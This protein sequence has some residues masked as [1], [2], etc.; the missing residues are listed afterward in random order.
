MK[1]YLNLFLTEAQDNLQTLNEELLVLEK[2]PKNNEA[3]TTL[4]RA[5]HTLKSS[6]AA[7]G[8]THISTLVHNIE[9]IF[10][11]IR[12]GKESFLPSYSDT[13]FT[14]FDTITTSL[15]AIKMGKPELDSADTIEALQ[16]LQE[17]DGKGSTLPKVQQ[18]QMHDE[19]PVNIKILDKLA[20]LS[21][22]LLVN[23]MQFSEISAGAKHEE[24]P[25]A[26]DAMARLITELQYNITQAR[27]VPLNEI[28]IRFP[29]LIRDMA[30]KEEKEIEFTMEGGEIELDRSIIGKIGEPLVHLLRNAVDHGIEDKGHIQLSATKE[31]AFVNISVTNTGKSINVE[32]IR[33][34]ALQ[35]NL[36]TAEESRELNASNVLHILAHPEFTTSTSTTESSGRGIGVNIVKTAVEGAGGKLTLESPLPHNREGAKFSLQLPITIAIVQALLVRVGKDLY[37]I[38]LS[39]VEKSVRLEQHQKKTA[40]NKQMAML[41]GMNIPMFHLRDLMGVPTEVLENKEEQLDKRTIAVIARKTGYS[42]NSKENEGF[43]ALVVDEI[44]I[45]QEVVVKSLKGMV[46]NVKGF[47]GITILGNGKPALILDIDTL[48]L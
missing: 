28:F 37:A 36:L 29:R 33:K 46:K 44:V 24:L 47:A 3:A 17:S 10:D 4:M 14:A 32:Q 23:R 8:Y 20:T 31:K 15:Q 6:S 22:E 12:S 48:L 25:M 16:H 13:L 26:V 7:M 30:S 43:Y 5:A 42:A 40:L 34:T 21:E 45:N 39:N 19:V 35:N 18:L 1:K 38:P 11:G 27:M 9:D 41:D 2:D